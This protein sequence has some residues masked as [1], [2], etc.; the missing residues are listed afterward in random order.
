MIIHFIKKLGTPD[1]DAVTAMNPEFQ[2]KKKLPKGKVPPM[3]GMLPKE[4]EEQ[5]ADLLTKL[6]KYKPNERLTALEAMAHPF[7]DELREENLVF[8]TGNCL[9]D[10]FNFTPFEMEGADPAVVENIVPEWYLEKR[11]ADL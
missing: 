8:P 5:G 11:R 7:F 10:L 4:T 3:S 6:L 9:C 2:S 1:K